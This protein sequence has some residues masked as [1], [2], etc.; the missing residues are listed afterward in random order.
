MTAA[1]AA[2]APPLVIQGGMGVAVSGWRLASTVS[3]LGQLGVVSGTALA[4]VLARGLQDGDPGG[5][6]RRALAAFT[7]RSVAARILQRYFRPDGR[8]PGAGYRAVP[9]PRQRAGRHFLEL[10]VAASFAEVFL[11]KEGHGRPVGMNLL[12]KVQIPTL[13]S[14]YGAMLAGVDWVLMGAGIPRH[15]PAA[16]RAL[17]DHQPFSLPFAVAGARPEDEDTVDFDPRQVVDGPAGPLR[18]PRFAAIVSSH[19]LAAH[20]C[21]DRED[22]P[23]GL[24][25][26]APVAGGHNAPP[27]GSLQ[28][29]DEGEPVYG[30]RDEVDLDRLRELGVPFWLAGGY[31]HP[32]RLQEALAAGACGVQVGTAFALC[33]ESGLDEDLRRRAREQAARGRLTVH[34]DPRASPTGYPFKVARLAGTVGDP[35]VA[36]ARP[37]RCD[38]SYLTTPYRRPDGRIGYR[39]PAEPVEDYVAKGGRAEDA[40]GRQCLCNG[41]TAAVGLAQVQPGAVTEPPLLTLGDEARETV[42]ALAPDGAPYTA[43]DVLRHL[44][45]APSPRG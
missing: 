41:L 22:R 20:L 42:A 12:E 30:P 38:L 19:V 23:D 35:A 29:T 14:L 13:P 18:R 36:A 26:E 6:L 45:T 44:L 43:A 8:R 5:H 11:A 28:L 32:E 31:G 33:E 17:A 27:R 3:R 24:V 16:L 15:I 1:A 34:S 4:V 25:V 7:D 9:V 40:E 2:P 10:T 39:C 37:R 21:R